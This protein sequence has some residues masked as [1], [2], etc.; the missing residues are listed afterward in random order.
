MR[1]DFFW[2]ILPAMRRSPAPVL[3]ILLAIFSTSPS[4]AQSSG[5]DIRSWATAS[6]SSL[7]TYGGTYVPVE[8]S[9]YNTNASFVAFWNVVKTGADQRDAVVLAGWQF[10]SSSGSTL[11]E[12][13]KTKVAIFEQQAD[14]TL[15]DA[16]DVLFGNATTDGIG[17]IQV[18]D[19]NRDGREDV[20]LPAHNESPELWRSSV[21]FISRGDGLFTRIDLTD[22]AANHGSTLF[23][24][25]G[26]PKVIGFSLEESGAASRGKAFQAIYSWNGSGFSVQRITPPTGLSGLSGVAGTFA[27]DNKTWVIVGDVFNGPGLP[28]I[29]EVPASSLR[30]IVG[31]SLT[32]DTLSAPPV[33]FPKPYFNDKPEYAQYIAATEPAKTHNPRMHSVDLNKDGLTDVVPF[34]TIWRSGIDPFPKSQLQL[35]INHGDMKFSDETGSLAPEFSEDSVIDYSM[36]IKDVDNSGIETFFLASPVKAYS[37][38]QDAARQS[39]YILVNDGT[40]RLYAAMHDE[41]KAMTEQLRTFV[42]TKVPQSPEMLTPQFV[43]YQTPNGAINFGVFV[44]LTTTAY[45]GVR[46]W[47]MVSLA[48]Q[49]NLATDFR[50]DLTV[51][52]RNGSHRIR[53]FAGNDTI[54]RALSDPDCSIDGGLG[55]NVVV[56]PGPRAS[57]TITRTAQNVTIKPASGPGGTDT[58]VRIQT[59][60]FSDGDVDLTQ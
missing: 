25:N 12:T 46:S 49:I 13:T 23:T 53:T 43:P 54:S 47:A 59:A 27:N 60:R 36:E 52:T 14:G 31:W 35:L 58:L 1:G 16:T 17:S 5:R 9:T 42:K 20:L 29:S 2:D 22:A 45:P 34:A 7:L 4:H 33:T 37:T 10:N 26:V 19:F 48:T 50:R 3:I 38:A 18:A 28:K 21:A 39:N 44:G 57:W 55:S 32:N 41:F 30:T 6:I 15:R 8:P 11:T 51:P 40:G 56:Y 24:V